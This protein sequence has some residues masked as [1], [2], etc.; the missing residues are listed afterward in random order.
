MANTI[1]TP[2]EQEKCRRIADYFNG[3]V[4]FENDMTI[5]DAGRYGFVALKY[6]S[7]VRGFDS[8]ETFTTSTKLFEFI[9]EDW[10][11]SALYKVVNG[12]DS[13]DIRDD[14][15]WNILSESKKKS[16][17]AQREIFLAGC[18]LA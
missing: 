12:T 1:I 18:G 7:P 5:L 15:I 10:Y 16:I 17:M 6:Y 2:Q 4:E 9:W 3:S 14:K 13:D 11:W 8:V